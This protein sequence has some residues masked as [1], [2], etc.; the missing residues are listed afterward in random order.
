MK[1]LYNYLKNYWGLVALALLLAAINTTFSLLDPY[2]FSKV[3]DGFGTHPEKYSQPQFINGVIWLL[4]GTMGVAMVSRIAKNFQDYFVNVIVQR[5]GAQIYQEGLRHSLLL[6]YETFE[7]QRS[8]QTLNI[9][10]KVR[11]D[12]E[13]FLGMMINI[14]FSTLIGITFV[15]IYSLSINWVIGPIYFCAVPIIAGLASLLSKKIKTVQKN[16]VAETSVLAG[17]TTESL[18]NIE[19]IKSLGLADQEINRLKGTTYKILGLELKKVKYIR[20]LSFIQG[21]SI[22]LIRTL[23]LFFMLT[24]VWQHGQNPLTGITLGQFFSLMFYSFFIFGPLQELGNVINVYRET[25]VS[26]NNLQNIL[27]MKIEEIP[28]SPIGLDGIQNISFENVTFKHQSAQFNAVED[29]SFEVYKGQTIA[30]V[31]PS[32]SGKTTLMKLLVGLYRAK[33][34]QIKINGIENTLIDLN[35]LRNQVGLVSQD[36]QLF[37]GSIRE[38]LLFAAPNATEEQCYDALNKA[39]CYTILN[40]S[41]KKIDTIIG[42]GGMKLSGGEKQRLSIARAILRNP[43]IMLFDEATSA[44]DSITESEI[45][46]TIQEISQAKNHITILI[47][48]RLS[49]VMHAD[50]IFVLEKGNIIEQGKHSDLILE[51]GLYYAMWRQ[52]I[53]ERAATVMA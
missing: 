47:A 46:Q 50:K 45:S 34:G 25:E 14:L 16:I 41:E 31:G 15:M 10:Q 49:T 44:L 23:I 35:T 18:R 36:T 13:R 38:N 32:G 3:T 29:I 24:L 40:R 4:C 37:S 28:S 48:H 2:I 26:F 42:E 22:N 8:G 6:P 21:T 9:L 30:F 17:S 20:T 51:K 19:L 12:F 5:L 53:G 11:S 1:L 33:K 43:D 39:S 27:D 7:D 52:Q